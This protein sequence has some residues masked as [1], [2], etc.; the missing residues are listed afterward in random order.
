MWM[1]LK[2]HLKDMANMEKPDTVM[3]AL[4]SQGINQGQYMFPECS[5]PECMKDPVWLERYNRGPKGFVFLLP[6]GPFSF[7]K[8][9]SLSFLFNLAIS[10]FATGTLCCFVSQGLS[11]AAAPTYIAMV[12]F[13]GFG[14][15]SVW[16]PIWKASS[17]R[18]CLLELMDAG[19]YGIAMAAPFYF[20]LP[21]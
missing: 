5:G 12:G 2:Y 16:G 7:G 15:S 10:A 20:L 1:V 8:A 11:L 18:V 14:A 6:P 21:S 9:L 17:V 3:D 4:R 19:L 13:L